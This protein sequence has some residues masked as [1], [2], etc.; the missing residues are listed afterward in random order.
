M[1]RC[2]FAIGIGLGLMLHPL[3]AAQVPR[4]APEF[5]IRQVNGPQLLLTQFRGKV[6]ALT[7]VY[8]TCPHCQ[9]FSGLLN[10]MYREYGPRG[11]Q[12]IDIAYNDQATL[13][14]SDF[15]NQLQLK[16]PVGVATREE[17]VSY[18]QYPMDKPMYVPQVV[19][20]DRKGVLRAQ[21]AG[22]SDFFQPKNVEANLR[23]EIESLLTKPAARRARPAVKRPV[24]QSASLSAA[25]GLQ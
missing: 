7:F 23:A 11:F 16:F 1:S 8:T 25:H 5:V 22:E 4:P 15:I 10:E 14:V 21:Y 12:P 17:V 20:I 2:L 18:L 24:P 3:G 13:L 6:V 9:H 19:F